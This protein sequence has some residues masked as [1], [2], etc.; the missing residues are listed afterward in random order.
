[1]TDG[2]GRREAPA[3]GCALLMDREWSHAARERIPGRRKDGKVLRVYPPQQGSYYGPFETLREQGF[4]NGPSSGFIGWL[5]ALPR[6]AP[7]M[8]KYGWILRHAARQWPSLALI[9]VLT[10]CT[11]VLAALQPW[12][13]K[14]LIDHAIGGAPLPAAP[15]LWLQWA[16]IPQTSG[17]LVITV[18]VAVFGIAVIACILDAGLTWAWSY[19]GQRMVYDLQEKLFQRLQRLSLGFHSKRTVGDSLSR[20]SGDAYCI[21]TLTSALIVGPWQHAFTLATIGAVA[22]TMDPQLAALSLALAPVLAVSVRYFG[23]RLK[24]RAREAREAQSSLFSLVHQTLGAIPVVQSF[25]AE[26]RIAGQFRLRSDRVVTLARRGALL[27]GA[28]G[29]VHGAVPTFG[30]AAVLYVGGLRVLSGDLALGSLL[31]FVAYLKAMQGAFRGF[32]DIYAHL[33]AV[34]A[35]LDRVREVI[36]AR[37]EI[38]DAPGAKPL[39]PPKESGS[40]ILLENVTFGYEPALPVIEDVSIEVH[41]GETIAL[42]G[43][44]GA[45]KSTLASL[46]PRFFDP[47]KG[48]VL[49]DGDDIRGA[50]LASVRARVSLVLQDPFLLPLSV[51]ENI[52]FGRPGATLEDIVAAAVAANADGFIRKLPGGYDAVIGE[53]GATLSGGEKQRLAIA[54]AILKDAPILI[55]DE[56]TSSVDTATESAILESFERLRRGRTTFIIAH[57]LSTTRSADRIAVIDSGRIVEMGTH[58]ELVAASGLYHRLITLQ[59][60]LPAA[61]EGGASSPPASI[62][63]WT[64]SAP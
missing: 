15:A 10:T 25:T 47:W 23:P 37:D 31:V 1:M 64:R 18:A 5:P 53:R 35:S 30:K 43:P 48:R 4:R 36:E 27:K 60:A 34:D 41:P 28:F 24:K 42:V 32:F 59:S 46:I 7:L 49:I 29:M 12:P 2:R 51:A 57:R 54:R 56:P 17:A 6:I 33:K 11:G 19:G 16:G 45:G 40:S 13:L 8:S 9:L 63:G 50:Q 61:V 52:A 39:A 20:I 38:R 3:P 44:T 62:T 58:D 14:L 21:Y 26:E 55:L 22:W